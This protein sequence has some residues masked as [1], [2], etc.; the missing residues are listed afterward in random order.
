MSGVPTDP[1]EFLRQDRADPARLLRLENR[2][3]A[4][5]RSRASGQ[6][7]DGRNALEDERNRNFYP[8]GHRFLLAQGRSQNP[9]FQRNLYSSP[10]SG[11]GGGNE[12]RR[13]SHRF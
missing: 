8:G 1:A 12:Q 9:L 11:S 6:G 7:R 10:G 5:R 13:L 4:R 2:G 3:K